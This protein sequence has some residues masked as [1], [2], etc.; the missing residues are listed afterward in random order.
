MKTRCKK[1]VPG[2]G[3]WHGA[4]ARRR[5]YTLVELLV[6]VTIAAVLVMLAVPAYTSSITRYRI[7]SEVNTLVADLQYARS[8]AVKQGI[9]VTM[10]ISTDGQTCTGN[11]TS[12]A[13]GHVVRTS[14]VGAFAPAAAMLRAQP[15]FGGTDTALDITA[16][17]TAI[18]FNRE[19]FAGVPSVVAWNGFASL[20]QSVLIVVHDQNATQGLGSCILVSVIGQ[21]SVLPSGSAPC[22]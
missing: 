18:T 9:N 21:V 11:T 4:A 20:Q 7:S 5:G 8:E 17:A 13:A 2:N 12:W 10:C 19:G 22:P 3:R 6:V 1:D 14:P 16:A 15:A